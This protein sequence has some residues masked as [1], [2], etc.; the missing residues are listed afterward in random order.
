LNTCCAS[1]TASS[2]KRFLYFMIVTQKVVR[3]YALTI[4]ECA[5]LYNYFCFWGRDVHSC[6]YL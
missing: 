4:Q 2:I 1:S 3:I 6:R 5:L